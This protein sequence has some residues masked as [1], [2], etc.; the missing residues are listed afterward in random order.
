[1]RWLFSI[2]IVILCNG[3]IPGS[4]TASNLVDYVLCDLRI[5]YYYENPAEIDWPTLYYLNDRFGC[6]LDLLTVKQGGAFYYR[7]V[8][9]A[10]KEIYS[11]QYYVVDNSS[12]YRDSLFGSLFKERRPD[13]VIF[14]HQGRE[15]LYNACRE[16]LFNLAVDSTSLFNIIKLYQVTDRLEDSV[17][18]GGVHINRHELLK[19]YQPR[20]EREVP[21]L[22]PRLRSSDY[23]SGKRLIFY[24]LLKSRLTTEKPVPDFVSGLNKIRLVAVLDS[25]LSEGTIKQAFIRKAKN[26]LSFLNASQNA[27]GRRRVENIITGYKELMYLAHQSRAEGM[28]AGIPDYE[29]YLDRLLNKARKAA[30]YE[31]GLNWEGRVIVRDSPHGQKL[32]FRADLAVNGAEEVELSYI[33]FHPY[34]DTSVIVLDSVSRKIKPHQAYVREYLVDIDPVYF[35]AAQPESLYFTAEVVYSKIQMPITTAVPVREALDLKISFMPGFRFVQPKARLDVDRVVSSLNW[36]ALI[37]KPLN[38]AGRVKVN[39]ETPRGVFAGAYR[40]E[41]LLEKGHASQTIPIPFSVSNL[42]ELGIH[43]QIIT[44]I[45]DNRVISADTGFIRIAACHIEDTV[46]IGFMPDSTGLLEDILRMTDAAFQPLTDRTL[47]T[48]D[49]NA[50]DVILVGSGAFRQYPSL[51]LITERLVDY[52]RN[53]GSLVIMGQPYDWPDGVLPVSFSPGATAVRADE[54]KLR[55]P[56]ARILDKPYKIILPEFLNY[57]T[58]R[59]PVASAVVSPAEKVFTTDADGTLLSISRL[60]NGQIIYC[61]LPLVEMI[62]ELNIG[63]IHLFA[64]ILNY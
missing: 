25:L 15:E 55:I 49:L 27:G 6:R 23:S 38:Y 31:I 60:G 37:T 35:E 41:W 34:W 59:Q 61:G 58:V 63:A 36:K 7:T 18:P 13:I 45:V 50:Y 54:I 30:L 57:F 53:G 64:N 20:L 39:L 22:F 19:Q 24:E 32:K 2:F 33:K 26:A 9:V 16:Y 11:H 48:G 1:M 47:V 28:L 5:L 52:L 3:L 51:T 42:F 44:L 29:P 46:Q 8:E 10:D 62:A 21:V 14:G 40:T 43:R 4:S 56:E 17:K 12:V